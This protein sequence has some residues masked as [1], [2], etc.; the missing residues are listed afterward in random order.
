MA[1]W[2][3]YAVHIGGDIVGMLCGIVAM[4][5]CKGSGGHVQAGKVFAPARLTMVSDPVC[6]RRPETAAK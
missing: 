4:I 2:P 5:Y 6:L 3:L 1:I